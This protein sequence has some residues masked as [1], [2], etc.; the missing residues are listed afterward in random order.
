MS[1]RTPTPQQQAA[2]TLRNTSV[3][4][5]AGA[6]C[7]KT[8]VLTE[9]FLSEFGPE[10]PD[11]LRPDEVGQIVAITFTDAAAREMRERIRKRCYQQLLDA[12]GNTEAVNYWTD[13]LRSLDEAKVSTIHSYC[14]TLIRAHA[15]EAGVDPQ[16]GVLEQAEA[17]SIAADVIDDVLREKLS[18]GNADIL[19]LLPIYP[20]DTLR[21]MLTSLLRGRERANYR[22][23]LGKSPESLIETWK[24]V[25]ARQAPAALAQKLIASPNVQRLKRLAREGPS[26]QPR[27]VERCQTIITLLDTWEQNFSPVNFDAELAQFREA[28]GIKGGSDWTSA[29]AKQA[30]GDVAK[31]VR[32]AID[33][34][35]GNV[36]FDENSALAAA[37]AGLQLLRIAVDVLD[38]YTARKQELQRLDFDDLLITAHHLLTNPDH[39]SVRQRLS[40][41]LRLLLVDEFQ[42]TDP[43]QV[44]LVKALCGTGLQSGKLFFVGDM[45][46]SIYRFRGAQPEVFVKL[47]HEMLE[48]GR[49]PLFTNFRSQPAILHFVNALFHDELTKDYR[50]LEPSRRQVASEPAIEFLWGHLPADATDTGVDALRQEEARWIA[51]RLRQ[52]LNEQKPIV[53]E[54][55]TSARPA[56]PGDIALLFRALTNVRY[57]EQALQEYGIPYYLVGGSAFYAQQ[58][59]YDVVNLLRAISSPVDAVALIGVL[60][61]PFF[62]LPD[63][64]VFWLGQ[65]WGGA[66]E[67]L[68]AGSL[69]AEIEPP[70]RRQVEFARDTLHTLR[71][72]KDRVPVAELLDRAIALTGYDAVLLAEFLG[73]RKLA[74]L[75]K[76]K[77]MARSFDASGIFSLEDFITRLADSVAEQPREAFAAIHPEEGDVVR[78]MSIHHSKGLEFPVV[79]VPD[80]D[81]APT[82][83]RDSVAFSSELGPLVSLPGES[84]ESEGM[85]SGLKLYQQLNASEEES[86]SRR[87]FYVATT[88]AADYLILSCC[89]KDIQQPTGSWT[90]L[91]S[92]HFDLTTG[93]LTAPLPSEYEPPQIKVTSELPTTDVQPVDAKARP[94]LA[95][96]VAKA[97]L[98]ASKGQGR[99]PPHAEP[100]QPD[101]MA[102]RQFSF[103]RL[104]GELQRDEPETAATANAEY[105]LAEPVSDA[106]GLGTLVHAVLADARFTTAA[107]L[108]EREIRQMV[109][110]YAERQLFESAEGLA[111]AIEILTDYCQSPLAARLRSAKASHTELEFL[112]GWPPGD[113]QEGAPC[114]NGFIDRLWQDTAG[115]WHILDFKT[116]RVTPDNLASTAAKYEM[117]MLLYALAVEQSLGV[118]PK[119]LTLYF[120]RTGK[121]HTFAWNPAARQRVIEMVNAAIATARTRKHRESLQPA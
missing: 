12:V 83:G 88:R 55:D 10:N 56:R 76:L 18:Q 30:F 66:T 110:Q 44:E 20:M 99:I 25:H 74:N 105:V 72:I 48:K 49:L 29:D 64:A 2:I 94:D 119:S 73:E 67:S 58:E 121:E 98:I 37:T 81:R 21:G 35:K 39:A 101:W 107:A 97:E 69:P 79:V 85:A 78:L 51:R 84:E 4:L 50:Q 41:Q 60:R 45:K 57:Y 11:A 89:A 114:L 108:S 31:K 75:L 104:T 36:A 106:I 40:S 33:R 117:Q 63:E 15:V 32:D 42:D 24:S 28:A 59:I 118:A 6:G 27:M 46:Q 3:A 92:R 120:L 13:L 116:N 26:S 14:A 91:L 109:L 43:L 7:G 113:A 54:S 82:G 112:L 100:L 16:F 103:S 77:E 52:M 102:R 8:T 93:Q 86:E 87:L 47:Q 23:W 115:D 53:W 22:D 1:L 38:R 19:E 9:R 90:N 5:S 61:S 68:F 80:M 96:I 111:T 71:Q 17:E 65:A 95:R 34:I 70:I 62:S